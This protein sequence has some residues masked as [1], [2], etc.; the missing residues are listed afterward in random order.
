MAACRSGVG[1][2]KR[3]FADKRRRSNIIFSVYNNETF[4]KIYFYY[5]DNHCVGI[6]FII[7]QLYYGDSMFWVSIIINVSW[8]KRCIGAYFLYTNFRI[9]TG[10]VI[11]ANYFLMMTWLPATVVIM[12]Q[13]PYNIC[14]C[15][16]RYSAYVKSVADRCGSILQ[17]QT[18][19]IVSK[20]NYC[21]ILAFGKMWCIFFTRS[22]PKIWWFD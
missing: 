19:R 4:G 14:I 8:Q 12:D 11:L 6:F 20:F 1:W 3:W 2:A 22:I 21:L 5:I 9:F 15:W 16:Q 10:T 7:L 13:N 18:I 17:S